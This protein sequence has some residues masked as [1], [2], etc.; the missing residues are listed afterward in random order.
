MSRAV[1]VFSFGYLLWHILLWKNEEQ[2]Y[3]NI[4]NTAQ[5][6][7]TVCVQHALPPMDELPGPLQTLTRECLAYNDLERP[8]FNHI[9]EVV[10][11][12]CASCSSHR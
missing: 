12:A 1:D 2:L 7:D 11:S 6:I 3:P 8:T 9:I 5:L 4:E 10:A